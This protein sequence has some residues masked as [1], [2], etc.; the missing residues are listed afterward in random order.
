MAFKL[1]IILNYEFRLYPRFSQQW[2]WKVTSGVWC[3][4]VCTGLHIFPRN[5]SRTSS[6]HG[7]IPATAVLFITFKFY[8]IEWCNLKFQEN[9]KSPL[10]AC[11]MWTH[12][13]CC[14]NCNSDNVGKLWYV[15]I[16]NLLGN[17]YIQDSPAFDF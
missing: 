17:F 4:V 13:M 5:I 12:W 16:W 3:C 2:L 14:Q 15:F 10:W 11:T 9:L 6:R 8:F 1:L 7:I